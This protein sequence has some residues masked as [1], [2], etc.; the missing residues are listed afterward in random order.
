MRDGKKVE[1]SFESIVWQAG[2]SFN[3]APICNLRRGEVGTVCLSLV[4]L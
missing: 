1:P 3:I 4:S 2:A